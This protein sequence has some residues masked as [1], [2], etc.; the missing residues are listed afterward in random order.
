MKATYA[1]FVTSLG[2][3]VA[4]I[5]L[6]AL[7]PAIAQDLGYSGEFSFPSMS[8]SDIPSVSFSEPSAS[9]YAFCPSQSSSSESSEDTGSSS[10]QS[11]YSFEWSNPLNECE[12][13][14]INTSTGGCM[15]SGS[16]E[17]SGG[18]YCSSS[19]ICTTE[20][21]CLSLSSERLCPNREKYCLD[22]KQICLAGNTCWRPAGNGLIAGTSWIVGY[23]VYNTD[24]KVVA[25][26]RAMVKKQMELDGL[27]YNAI[28]FDRY[29][30]VLGIGVNTEL[31]L[32]EGWRVIRDHLSNGQYSAA[33]Q[34]LY[35]SLKG[36]VFGELACHSNGAMICLA[37]IE[38]GDVRAD[39]IVLYGPQVTVESLLKWNDLVK[40]GVVKSV[41]IYINQNDPVTPFAMLAETLFTDA[42]SGSYIR[43]LV[44]LALFNRTVLTGAIY[45]IAPNI[46]VHT[47]DCA[48]FLPDIDCHGL[49]QYKY[50]RQRM[51]NPYDFPVVTLKPIKPD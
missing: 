16:H 44:G 29:Q 21:T 10:S 1:K 43:S 6:L 27:P 19:E 35:N 22:P 5:L 2:T 34:G 36:R 31:T 26:A 17:C 24:P 32:G 45:A 41:Q 30:F 38:N 28:D 46:K 25:R 20:N 51:E 49:Q 8:A 40:K 13:G 7:S 15:P 39:N 3:A 14:W 50:N 9:C 11:S 18:N 42:L 23:S 4:L 12:P 37:A 33:E 48:S 47:F